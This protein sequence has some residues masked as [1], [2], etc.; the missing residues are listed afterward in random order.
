MKNM[1][2]TRDIH[3]YFDMT[4]YQGTQGKFSIIKLKEDVVN[5]RTAPSIKEA[6]IKYFDEKPYMGSSVTKHALDISNIT[7]DIRNHST[8]LSLILIFNRLSRIN[9]DGTISLI[10]HDDNIEK[11]LKISQIDTILDITKQVSDL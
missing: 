11:L 3:N 6:F 1:S 10:N 4:V 5:D 2:D 7:Y 9:G 8:L